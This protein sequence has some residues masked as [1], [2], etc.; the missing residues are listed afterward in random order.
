MKS[1]FEALVKLKFFATA[2][3]TLSLK[4]I[5]AVSLEYANSKFC[6]KVCQGGYS[7]A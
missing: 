6:C 1:S 4:S 7:P 5:Y 2:R 3:N